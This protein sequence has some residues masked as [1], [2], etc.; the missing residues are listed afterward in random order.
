MVALHIVQRLPETKVANLFSAKHDAALRITKLVLI[1]QKSEDV[2]TV[3]T[4]RAPP[5]YGAGQGPDSRGGRAGRGG[6]RLFT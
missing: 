5:P 6:V 4:A 2:L 1:R 3:Y